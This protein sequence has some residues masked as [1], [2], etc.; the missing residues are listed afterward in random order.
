VAEQKLTGGAAET[1]QQQFRFF[2]GRAVET[3]GW[4]DRL[5]PA[6]TMGILVLMSDV[7]PITAWLTY[8]QLAERLG[9]RSASAAA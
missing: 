5:V 2:G 4:L 6:N 3:R 9:L 1:C 7:V 8:Q